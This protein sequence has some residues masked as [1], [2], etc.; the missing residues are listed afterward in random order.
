METAPA[1]KVAVLEETSPGVAV[2]V[3][4][5]GPVAIPASSHCDLIM[6]MLPASAPRSPFD[7]TKAEHASLVERHSVAETI[8]HIT[9]K[10]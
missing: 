10:A 3:V 5:L 9:V 6:L 1:P 2:V 4:V 7:W 8:G